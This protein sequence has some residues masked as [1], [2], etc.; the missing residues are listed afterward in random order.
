MS[1]FNAFQWAVFIGVVSLGVLFSLALQHFFM[2][3][4]LKPERVARAA[5]ERVGIAGDSLDYQ[6]LGHIGTGLQ[7]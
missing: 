4:V 3:I 7:E 5:A 6:K 2:K 1:T